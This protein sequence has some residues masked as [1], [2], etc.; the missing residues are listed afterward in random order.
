MDFKSLGSLIVSSAPT[1]AG[2]LGGPFASTAVSLLESAFGV[3]SDSLPQAIQ[4]D[5]EAQI[6]LKKLELD[7]AEAMQ[8]LNDEDVESARDNEVKTNNKFFIN[9]LTIL[10][11]IGFFGAMILLAFASE[12]AQEVDLLKMMVGILGTAWVSAMNFHYGA[13]HRDT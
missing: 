4:S 10:L 9:F 2:A 6:K 8:R 7:H 13:T 12:S 11:T 1:I 5:P 3:K